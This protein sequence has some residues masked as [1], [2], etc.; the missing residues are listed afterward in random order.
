MRTAVAIGLIDYRFNSLQSQIKQGVRTAQQLPTYAEWMYCVNKT[1]LANGPIDYKKT[2][3]TT[4][5]FI[6]MIDEI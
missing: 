6:A 5:R 2:T 1:A 3:D 4:H